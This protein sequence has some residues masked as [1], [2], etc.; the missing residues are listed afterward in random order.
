MLT[1]FPDLESAI[2]SHIL[3]DNAS[4]P[5]ENE[6]LT[7]LDALH[8]HARHQIRLE[9]L[10][11]DIPNADSPISAL[12]SLA[13]KDTPALITERLSV[14][15]SPSTPQ[16]PIPDFSAVTELTN[17]LLSHPSVFLTPNILS[18]FVALQRLIKDPSPI[19]FIFHLYA[20]KPVLGR[21]RQP[22]GHE[23][24][25]AIPSTIADSA[26]Q[27]SLT[28]GDITM[29]LDIIDTS[30]AA[31]AFRRSKV[32][33][34]VLPSA[35]IATVAPV[36]FWALA[37]QMAH[38][39]DTVDYSVAVRYAFAGL[40]AYAGLTFSFGLMALATAN[41]QMVRVTWIPGTPLRERWLREEER[42]AL[43]MVAMAWG[44]ND[45]AK[46]GFE[47]GSE[48]DLLREVVGRKG[49]ILDEPSLMDGMQ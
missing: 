4:I 16:K 14:P 26:L 40:M 6:I 37:D 49:M 1:S 3:K 22:S 8:T 12:L 33:S 10:T 5:P 7:A 13:S 21:Q 2:A 43:D 23:A 36:A 9:K 44:F 11:E 34:R 48:W 30:F 47:E 28:S 27:L 41:D 24:K 31:P 20:N 38:W 46:R 15:L 17:R 32:I 29:A 45:A 42:K 18:S 19:P 25:N 39:Q 35:S